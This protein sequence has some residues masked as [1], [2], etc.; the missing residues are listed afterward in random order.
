MFAQSSRP[1]RWG[2][3]VSLLDLGFLVSSCAGSQEVFSGSFMGDTSDPVASVAVVAAEPEQGGER[4]V[5]AGFE[6]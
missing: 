2:I 4:E 1:L 3:V 6:Q 5:R